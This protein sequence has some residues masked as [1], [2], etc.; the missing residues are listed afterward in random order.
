MDTCKALIMAANRQGTALNALDRALEATD[1]GSPLSLD[2][3]AQVL[4]GEQ[5][6][7][8]VKHNELNAATDTMF[9]S[10]PAAPT[11]DR[12][13]ESPFNNPHLQDQAELSTESLFAAAQALSRPQPSPRRAPL[14]GNARGEVAFD[15]QLQHLRAMA[16]S[17]SQ[18]EAARA[19]EWE[20]IH[21]AATLLQRPST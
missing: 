16:D 1:A 7:L 11:T 9:G 19:A 8:A 12:H 10:E 4:A 6:S 15:A 20:R 5:A 21:Q 2:G 17:L 18:P 14:P 3:V 13:A